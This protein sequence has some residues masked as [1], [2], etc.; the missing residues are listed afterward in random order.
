MPGGNRFVQSEKQIV[1]EKFYPC[2][3]IPSERSEKKQ[4]G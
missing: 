2:L 1:K 3:Q 4:T